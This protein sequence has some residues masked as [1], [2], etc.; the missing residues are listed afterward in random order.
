MGVV[1]MRDYEH[2]PARAGEALLAKAVAARSK[3]NRINRKAIKEGGLKGDALFEAL[4]SETGRIR[5]LD[6]KEVF[7]EL[8]AK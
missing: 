1:I 5:G 7:A 3:L 6:Y 8:A 4:V 2:S